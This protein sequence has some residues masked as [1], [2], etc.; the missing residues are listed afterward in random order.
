[1]KNR[2]LIL[3]AIALTVLCA[4][5]LAAQGTSY[6]VTLDVFG[7]S[8]DA[9]DFTVAIEQKTGAVTLENKDL[10]DGTL[11]LEF[12]SVEE[13]K[14]IVDVY[15]PDEYHYYFRLF[16]HRFGI[17]T[18]DEYFGDCTGSRIV[19]LSIV[20]Y[21]L[22][23]IYTFSVRLRQ[24]LKENLYR[25][26][27]IFY[28]GLLLFLSF[29]LIDQVLRTVTYR[30]PIETLRAMLGA[31]QSFSVITLPVAFV[32]AVFVTAT[33]I[34]LM[35]REGRNWRNLLGCFLGVLLCFG[36]IFP[37]LLYRMLYANPVID[38]HNQAG[39]ATHV[40]MLAESLAGTVTS[41]L[42][43]VLL[44]T[45]ILGIAAAKRTP[46][47]D[48]DYMIILGC[49][50]R[51]DG[52]PTPLLQGR[53]DRALAFAAEQKEKT[54]KDLVFVPSGGQGADEPLSEAACMKNYLLAKGVPEERILCEDRST[55]T[56]TNFRNSLELIRAHSG[57][58][59]PQIAFA[60]TNYHVLRSGMIASSLGAHAEGVGSRTK[61][62]FWINA[63][64]REFI[65]SLAAEKKRHLA[66]G[67]LL[68]L[69]NV[70]MVWLIYQS[71]IR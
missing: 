26:R 38:V 27:N 24:S 34:Q 29:L 22:L 7:V 67:A 59:D 64:V 30:G 49:R 9:G 4:A 13:G 20:L 47:Y 39:V 57:Q 31:M 45:V 33:N 42:E 65:A 1:M 23:L 68:V 18:Y 28:I 15:G 56:E 50:M 52:T 35:R 25:Y 10:K 5:F 66:A 71:N 61:R 54:G 40:E 46:V 55:S 41:Y 11:Y 62:Y 51:D 48:K 36:T 8:D 16:S 32:L 44:G 70:L 60:T 58:E 63:F 12:R 19:P 37:D 14:A 69:F 21:L 6:I 43:C 2:T 53:V 3:I 17:L